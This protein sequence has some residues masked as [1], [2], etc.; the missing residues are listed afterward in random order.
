MNT[1]RALALTVA[2]LMFCLPSR[3]SGQKASERTPS[4]EIEYQ[5]KSGI[6]F[7]TKISQ[8]EDVLT[9]SSGLQIQT[10]K[11][12][13]GQR[14]RPGDLVLVN[15]KG[16]LLDGRCFSEGKEV[17]FPVDELIEGFREGLLLMSE[18]GHAVIVIPCELAYGDQGTEVIPGGATLLFDVELI[19]VQH[20]A[21]ASPAR[22]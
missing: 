16:F 13:T 3:A 8:R 5:K 20:K 2:M 12:G 10:I 19:K 15:Y 7:M 9:M 1:F 18:G 6:A 17:S 22:R 14:P 21:A 11:V 4:E